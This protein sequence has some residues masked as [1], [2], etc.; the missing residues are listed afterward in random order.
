MA[1]AVQLSVWRQAVRP[2]ASRRRHVAPR[3]VCVRAQLLRQQGP[4]GGR[5]AE[6]NAGLAGALLETG[7][8]GLSRDLKGELLSCT[9]A[10]A[11]A[12]ASPA[13][14]RAV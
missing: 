9:S 11:A 7:F 10:A 4:P 12:T 13:H 8:K 5:K 14:S 2:G 6:L 1:P 3:V